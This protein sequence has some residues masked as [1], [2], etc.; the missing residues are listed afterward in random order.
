MHAKSVQSDC[1]LQGYDE[2]GGNALLR[3]FAVSSAEFITA[4]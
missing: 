2:N 1:T 4:I 3:T